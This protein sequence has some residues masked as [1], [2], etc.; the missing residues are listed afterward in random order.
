MNLALWVV[1]LCA[2]SPGCGLAVQATR[3]VAAEMRDCVD[4]CREAARARTVARATW[5]A[6]RQDFPAR[7]YSRDYAAGFRDGVADF[8]TTGGAGQL[9]PVPPPRYLR[10]DY[11]TEQEYQALQDWLTGFRHGA[12]AA[13]GGG[14]KPGQAPPVREPFSD[15]VQPPPG[16]QKPPP[17]PALTPPRKVG[18]DPD[19]EEE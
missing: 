14:P 11:L 3:N 10:G 2:V 16:T 9:L 12:A 13:Q 4:D 7:A 1:G 8:V 18:P 15:S 19:K 17:E 5:S 6:A